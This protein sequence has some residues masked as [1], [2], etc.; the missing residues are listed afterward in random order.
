MTSRSSRFVVVATAAMLAVS[1]R[2]QSPAISFVPP[3]PDLGVQL[4][5]TSSPPAQESIHNQ[6]AT[7]MVINAIR[8]G[9]RDSGD[10]AVS[11]T[12]MLPVTLLPG[13][14]LSL[15]ITFTPDAPWTPGSRHARLIVETGQGVYPLTLTGMGVTCAG[16]VWAATT[17]GSCADTDGDG[18]ND[19]WEDNGYIDL[20]NNGVEDEGDFRFPARRSHIFSD[21]R[22]S[23]AGQGQVFPTVTDPSLPV[24]SATVAVTVLTDG[25]VGTATF[26]YSLDGHSSSAARPIRP[27]VDVSHN[28]RLMFYSS[29]AAGDVFTFQTSMG[30]GGK[31]AD[32]NVPNVYVQYDYMDWDTG[33]NACSV[34]SDCDAGGS[35]LN[36]TCHAGSCSHNHFPGDPLYRKVVDQ[37]A[38]HG[39][40][41]YIS[42]VHRPVPHAQVITW[43]QP[44][45][46]SSGASASCAGAD[47]IAGNIGPGQLAVCFRDI[48]YRPGSVFSREP[49]QK[50]VYHYAVISHASSCLTDLP[51]VPGSCKSCPA[52]RGTPAGFPVAT[53]SGTAEIP[54]NDFIVSLGPTLN[55]GGGPTN[56]FLEGGV[57]M[58]E[59][60]HNLGLHHA[61][62]LAEPPQTPNYLSVMNYRYTVTGI[63]HAATPGSTVSVE[64]LRELNY[65]EHELNTLDEASLDEAAGVSPLSSGYTGIVRFFNA[66]GG[67][68]GIGPEAGPIDWTGNG[69]IDA[70]TVSVD[71]NL[72]NGAAETM[73]GYADW[74]HGVCAVVPPVCRVNA[75]RLNIHDNFDPAIDVY[76]PCV[77]NQCQSLWL[78]FQFTPWGKKD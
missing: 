47:V 16:L 72:L 66:L 40:T 68:T 26:T 76:E 13:V 24:P 56:P 77:Q 63:T 33:G 12:P 32:K 53:S 41:L 46:G 52:D 9:G 39:I 49:L 36:S 57:F 28:L 37:F 59:L 70:G 1:A 8:L 67:N 22:H 27:V 18:F 15:Q 65:S 45:D 7:P 44:G 50:D 54:G 69:L 2:G 43:S 30:L 48:K 74:T 5:G 11:G 60:G 64:T 29:F 73:K 38:K 10:F 20:N 42:P 6:A 3:N 34:D 17:D 51:G 31:I 21:V 71:L 25:P 75:I 35:Q 62:D 14:S 61:G 19:A 4:L 58:H 23:G 78:A 55:D